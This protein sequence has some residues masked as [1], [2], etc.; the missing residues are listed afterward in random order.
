MARPK[1]LQYDPK[2]DDISVFGYNNA[3]GDFER[4]LPDEAE[5]FGII[6]KMIIDKVVDEMNVDARISLGDVAKAIANRLK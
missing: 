2:H 3:V 4:F 5:I 1:K 6:D